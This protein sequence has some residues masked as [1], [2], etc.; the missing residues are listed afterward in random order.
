[1]ID[2]LVSRHGLP[3]ELGRIADDE[4]EEFRGILDLNK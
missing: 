3:G 1:M 2:E 4:R